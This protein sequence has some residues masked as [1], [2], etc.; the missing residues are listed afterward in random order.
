MNECFIC[1]KRCDRKESTIYAGR[2]FDYFGESGGEVVFQVRDS[3]FG[4]PKTICGKCADEGLDALIAMIRSK[5]PA[6]GGAE[7]EK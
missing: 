4:H 6:T 1:R 3:Q 7:G 5:R 2:I